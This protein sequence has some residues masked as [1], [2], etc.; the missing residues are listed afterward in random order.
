MDVV[1]TAKYIHQSPRKVRL[2]TSAVSSLTPTEAIAQLRLMDKKA[3]QVVIDVLQSAVANA[4]HNFK[5]DET[6]LRIKTLEVNEAPTMKRYM[7]RSRGRANTILK[8]MAHVRVVLTDEP[9]VLGKRRQAAAQ[10][11]EHSRQR[12]KAVVEAKKKA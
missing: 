6:S 3:S 2:V 10:A 7:A 8:R 9:R 5:L 4:T 11:K 12:S 1:A